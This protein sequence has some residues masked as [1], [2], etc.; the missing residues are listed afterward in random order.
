[1]WSLFLPPT[2]FYLFICLFVF[3]FLFFI[4]WLC[5]V[6]V[7][8][9]RIFV[10]ACGIFCCSAQAPGRVR[11]VVC[12]AWALS[13]RRTGSGVMVHGLSC[14]AASGILVPRP[15]IEPVSPVLEG[16]FFTTG[17]PRK[18]LFSYYWVLR[19]I[20]IFCVPVLYQIW[21]LQIFSPN[22]CFVFSISW[23][24]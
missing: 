5:Q 4:F 14:P 21:V 6:L 1:M 2:A 3:I 7:V 24:S 8:A 19:E 11:S 17:P 23:V 10:E 20:C 12:G 22:L 16:R 13:L 15:G 18:S 9:C